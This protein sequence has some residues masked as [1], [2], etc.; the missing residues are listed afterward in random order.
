[1]GHYFRN[2]LISSG[3][4]QRQEPGR[5]GLGVNE[6]KS[7]TIP[8][9]SLNQEKVYLVIEKMPEFPGGM[10]ALKAFVAKNLVYP[11]VAKQK[12]IE[13]VVVLQFVV[14]KDGSLCDIHV[15]KSLGVG[16]DEEARRILS[17]SPRW[18]PGTQQG[19]PYRV[20]MTMP[21]SFSL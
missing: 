20:K 13:G 2:E 18:E 17:L 21:V 12:K 5:S 16:C 19:R 1:M 15:L 8:C 4:S 7:V 14:E 10:A 11:E 9:D 6:E 3:N